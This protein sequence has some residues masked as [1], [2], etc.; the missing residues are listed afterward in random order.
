M[1]YKHL[2][3]AMTVQATPEYGNCYHR[4]A[5]LVLDLPGSELCIGS[6]R[7]ATDEEL[8][9]NPDAPTEP[10]I[11]AW[12]EKSGLVYSPSTIET[13]GMQLLPITRDY[14]YDTNGAQN[15]KRIPRKALITLSG[16]I[17][18]SQHILRNKDLKSEVDLPA[19]LIIA[20]A[21]DTADVE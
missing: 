12:V 9:Q 1:K 5:A 3:A 6:F 7:G 13:N 4:S 20:A 14:Y 10:Y 19:A 18:L 8:A 2:K 11:H 17:N 15:V 21:E 16:Q